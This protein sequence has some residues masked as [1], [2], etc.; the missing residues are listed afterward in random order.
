M[1]EAVLAAPVSLR[2]P[3]VSVRCVQVSLGGSVG[4]LPGFDEGSGADGI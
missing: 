2:P 3:Q 4:T 1:S